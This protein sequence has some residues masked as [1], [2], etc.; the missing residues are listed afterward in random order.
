MELRNAALSLTAVVAILLTGPCGCA[1]LVNPFAPPAPV[2]TT[3]PS[4]QP[5]TALTGQQTQAINTANA[6]MA[7][8]DNANWVFQLAAAFDPSLASYA[9]AANDAA[10]AVDSLTGQYTAAVSAGKVV[11]AASIDKQLQADIQTVLT[12]AAKKPAAT[13]P[14]AAGASGPSRAWPA[15][16]AQPAM[17]RK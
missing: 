2:A 9:V 17:A 14:K 8:V 7:V 4:T 16:P 5:T 10:E 13:Q 11:D 3:Q 6:A 15:S 12:A 1:G